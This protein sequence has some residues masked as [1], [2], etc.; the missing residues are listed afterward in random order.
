M[1]LLAPDLR[2]LSAG[3]IL[4]RGIR[5][6]RNNF[7]SFLGIIAL[8]GFLPFALFP[9]CGWILALPGVGAIVYFSA[10]VIPLIASVVVLEQQSGSRALSRAWHLSR[11]RFWWVLGF[12][13]LLQLFSLIIVSAWF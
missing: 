12:F 7:L 11:S 9:F 2:P 4:D 6:Y 1:T 5:L 13:F 10:V 3:Q 8:I